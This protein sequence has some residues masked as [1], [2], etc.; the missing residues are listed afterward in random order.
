[1][2]TVV[3]ESPN[4]GPRLVIADVFSVCR[5]ADAEDICHYEKDIIRKSSSS[6]T[7]HYR[8]MSFHSSC[9]T[10]VKQL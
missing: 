3:V 5:H 8:T 1:M 6:S 2:S 9:E 4:V 10:N 7:V